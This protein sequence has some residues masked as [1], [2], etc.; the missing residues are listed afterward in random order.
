MKFW[1]S[2]W[3]LKWIRSVPKLFLAQKIF[4]SYEK[5]G[6]EIGE[7]NLGGK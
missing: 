1:L 2:D 6:R 5:L 7:G 4:R 3:F